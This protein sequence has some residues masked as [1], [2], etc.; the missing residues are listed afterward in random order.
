MFCGKAGRLI[1]YIFCSEPPLPIKEI[2]GE[3]VRTRKLFR[4]LGPNG[5]GLKDENIGH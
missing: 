4:V 5:E 2:L 3:F 1:S